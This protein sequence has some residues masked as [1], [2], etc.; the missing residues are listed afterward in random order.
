M[1]SRETMAFGVLEM[2]VLL[3]AVAML[4]ETTMPKMLSKMRS[5]KY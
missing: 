3:M 4:M 2:G 5:N 1:R